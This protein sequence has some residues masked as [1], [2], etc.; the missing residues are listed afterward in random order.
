LHCKAL[1]ERD[2]SINNIVAKIK[3]STYT[4]VEIGQIFLIAS[5][6]PSDINVELIQKTID[7]SAVKE[8]NLALYNQFIKN[9]H[10]N[11]LSNTLKHIDALR[12]IIETPNTDLHLVI[13]DDMLFGDDLCKVLNTV[14]SKISD[15]PIV[16]LGLPSNESG[17]IDIKETS[18]QFNIIPLVDSYIIN[19]DTAKMISDNI[20]PIKFTTVFQF[21]YI[22]QKC[23]V[24]SFQSSRNVFV[25]GSKY[26]MF[27]SSLNPN[28][29]LVFNKDYVTLLEIVNRASNTA[30][31]SIVVAKMQRESP[32]AK[33][34]DFMYLIAKFHIK[35]KNYKEAEKVLSEAYNI[36]LSNNGI[37]NHESAMLK[38]FITLFKH[39]QSF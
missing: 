5:N 32:I 14:I 31:D 7:Y 4:N 16:F 29:S 24:K 35:E 10:V 26:G 1:K 30:D 37:V 18:A 11:Q 6:D 27:V 8:Q 22:L 21:N 38:D 13:E 34:P 19:Y 36:A 3:S 9:I 17:D 15:Q 28:N 33:S 23:S 20:F 12:K 39:L 2:A 25:N